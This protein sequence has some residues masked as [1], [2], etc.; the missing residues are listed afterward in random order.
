MLEYFSCVR[1][2][3]G[4]FRISLLIVI[5][6]GLYYVPPVHEHLAWRLDDLRT[7]IIY[8]V[9]PPSQAVFVPQVS[10]QVAIDA[11]VQ[12]MMQAYFMAQA[13]V[14]TPTPLPVVDEA[15][16]TPTSTLAPLPSSVNLPGVVYMDQ[17][18]GYNL[19]W[20]NEF[21]YGVEILGLDRRPRQH[22]QSGQARRK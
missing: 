8:L 18:G 21:I 10:Q 19:V 11:I 15:T 5:A 4:V 20:P 16:P 22:Y 14:V 12:V 13:Q 9:Q 17:S 7:R 2:L 3:I 6:I 1:V